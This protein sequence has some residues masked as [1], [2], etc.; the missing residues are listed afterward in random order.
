MRARQHDSNGRPGRTAG[1]TLLE[2]MVVVAIVAILA[3]VAYPSYADYITRSRIIQATTSLSDYRVKME[4]FFQDNRTYAAAG[5][6]GVPAPALGPND[7]FQ[8]VCVGAGATPTR[9]RRRGSAPW[10]ARSTSWP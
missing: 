2:V 7:H 4:Q 5:V 3:S 1:F 8:L 10:R 9:S 6:C